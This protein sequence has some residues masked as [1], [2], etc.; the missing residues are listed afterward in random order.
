MITLQGTPSLA[1]TLAELPR[2][3]NAA[4][5]T[6]W[7]RA[8]RFNPSTFANFSASDILR[9]SREDLIQI[10]G[11][12]DGIRLFN[13]LHSKAPIPKLTLYFSLEGNDSLWRVAYFDNLSSTTFTNKLLNTLNLPH[14]R[15]H[16]ILFLGPQ[17]IHVMITDELVANMK[18]ESMY[19]IET[20]KGKFILLRSR[21]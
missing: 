18:D 7:L 11:V 15:L 8:S 2:D 14:D 9:L 12:P 5:T 13:T 21:L 19:L 10:C 3:A 17:G 20:I 16:S 4:Q 1:V 6:A